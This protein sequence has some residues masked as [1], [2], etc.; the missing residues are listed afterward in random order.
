MDSTVREIKE[1]LGLNIDAD[2]LKRIFTVKIERVLKNDTYFSKDFC[3]VYIL[4]REI[5]LND[6][7]LQS[8]EVA[9]AKWIS[10]GE[11]KELSWTSAFVS[12]EEEYKKLFKYLSDQ[13]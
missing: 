12:R 4:R 6:L 9:A 13:S 3:D 11:L 8:E 5:K 2:D 7:M 10:I 1:E